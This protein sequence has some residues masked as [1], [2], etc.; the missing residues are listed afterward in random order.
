[1]NKVKQWGRVGKVITDENGFGKVPL[2]GKGGVKPWIKH[3]SPGEK[4]QLESCFD[5]ASKR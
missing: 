1:L 4:K 2:M 5:T 3:R